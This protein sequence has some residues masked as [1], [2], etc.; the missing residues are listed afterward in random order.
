MKSF[1]MF[2]IAVQILV[3]ANSDSWRGRTWFP[4]LTFEIVGNDV[5][6][7]DRIKK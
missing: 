7:T 3:M 1:L 5:P 4:D 2:P 6:T